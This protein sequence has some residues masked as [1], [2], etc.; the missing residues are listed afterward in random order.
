MMDM[1]GS[2]FSLTLEPP[3]ILVIAL[4]RPDALN[5]FLAATKRDLINLLVHV[6][7]ATEIRVVI[8][9]GVGR[10][11]C[12]G[13]D[14]AGDFWGG[15][16][17]DGQS[18]P[19]TT[20]EG[21]IGTYASLRTISQEVNRRVRGLD[22]LTIA[23]INGPAIQSGLSLALACDFRIAAAGAKLGSATLRMG[24][25]PDEGGHHLL[26]ELIGTARTMDFLMRRRIVD[27]KT[28]HAIGLVNE[29]VD[30]PYDV[31]PRA[32]ELAR[33]LADGPQ[34]AMRLLKRAVYNATQFTF[35][36]AGEDI[37]ARAAISD[38]HPD[39]KEG[40]RAWEEKRLP[41]FNDNAASSTEGGADGH[42]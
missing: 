5:G 21:S 30:G 41:R 6:Q 11:F 16:W 40:A 25:L 9:T 14:F 32:L 38:H 10:A 31:L 37:A 34:V 42:D 2:G 1:D 18:D 15:G 24:F 33:E 12:A 17:E 36:Q 8:F 4:D 3:G 19:I 35:E 39:A 7:Y 23:A 28:A 27:G 26:V 20:P 29:V 13:D 22:K